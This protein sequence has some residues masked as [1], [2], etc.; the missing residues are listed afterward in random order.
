[1]MKGA[2]AESRG[3]TGAAARKGTE[4]NFE[5][6]QESQCTGT[7][8]ERRPGT[9]SGGEARLRSVGRGS[10]GRDAGQVAARG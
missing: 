3:F 9:H 1:M 4:G 8:R 10:S 7:L 2:G 5:G 6:R